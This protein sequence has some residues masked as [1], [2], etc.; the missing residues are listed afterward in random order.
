MSERGKTE[1]RPLRGVPAGSSPT[2]WSVPVQVAEVPETGRRVEIAA[3]AA[4]REAV[5]KAVG[6]LALPSLEAAFDLA[7]VADGGV[8]VCGT[9][10]ATVQQRCVVTLDPVMTEVREPIDLTFLPPGTVEGTIRTADEEEPPEVLHGGTV[11]LGVLTTEFLI[12]GIDP[13]PRKPGVTFD[14]P[15]SADDPAAHPFAALAAL[16]KKGG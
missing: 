6:V 2:P 12:L 3:D 8:R 5:A 14:A 11:D 7:P 1:G 15:P 13:Y 9:V 4:T 16:K 10:L